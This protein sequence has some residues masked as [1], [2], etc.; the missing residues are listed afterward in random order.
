GNYV[1]A[2]LN[3]DNGAV[4]N[5]GASTWGSGTTGVSGAVSAANSLVGSTAGDF[6]GSVTALTSGNYVVRSPNWDNGAVANAGA[7]TWGSGTTGVSGVVSATNSLVGTTASTNLQQ[8]V[9]DDVNATFFGRFLAEGG[10]RV[11]VAQQE[12]DR[13]MISSVVDI[14]NDQG[15]Q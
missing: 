8:V 2:S 15:R 9:V 5:A 4:V 10:G 12:S 3:W 13:P 7:A 14:R 1:V 11:R 6:V